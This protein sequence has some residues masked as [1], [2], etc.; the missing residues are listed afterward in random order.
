MAELW[1]KFGDLSIGRNGDMNFSFIASSAGQFWIKEM[2]SF[3]L[4]LVLG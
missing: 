2:E 4:A 3:L 1:L